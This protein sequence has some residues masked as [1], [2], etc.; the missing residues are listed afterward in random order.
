MFEI[1]T[2]VGSKGEY[3]HTACPTETAETEKD[4]ISVAEE[5]VRRFAYE[6]SVGLSNWIRNEEGLVKYY[7]CPQSIVKGRK[8]VIADKSV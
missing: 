7:K 3:H 2:L 4:A 1:K 6:H 5:I 8:I